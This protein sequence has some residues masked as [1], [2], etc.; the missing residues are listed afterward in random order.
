MDPPSFTS[1]QKGKQ[2]HSEDDSFPGDAAYGN[3][4]QAEARAALSP[5]GSSSVLL[6]SSAP[7]VLVEERTF[8]VGE[9]VQ[10]RVPGRHGWHPAVVT[11]AVLTAGDHACRCGARDCELRIQSTAL[12]RWA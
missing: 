5:R 7:R 8:E 12:K 2:R 11:A 4:A 3:D 1:P 6:S 9:A 10:V